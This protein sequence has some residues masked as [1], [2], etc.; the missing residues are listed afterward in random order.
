MR[1]LYISGALLILCVI[2]VLGQGFLWVKH[3][4][5]MGQNVPQFVV[6]DNQGNVYVAGNFNGE[7]LQNNITYISLGLQDMFLVKYD[8]NGNLLWSRQLGGS[9]TENVYGIALSTDQKSIYLGFTF[10]GTTNILG[11][12]LTAE[13]NDIAVAKITSNGDLEDLYLVA[14]GYNHQ[15]N[16]NL[17]VDNHNNLYVLGIFTNE[18]VIAGGA[19]YL[20]DNE[21]SN[22]QN[23][24]VKFDEW[25]NFKWVKLFETTSPLTYIRSITIYEDYIYLSGQFSGTLSFPNQ[26][27]VSNNSYRDGF[28]A[29]LNT[30]GE[31]IWVRRIRGSG[32]DIYIHRHNHDQQGNVYLAGYF[33]CSQLTI[34]S[35]ENNISNVFPQNVAAGKNDMLLL[36]YSSDGVLQ[37]VKNHGSTGDDRLY[38]INAVNQS[39]TASGCYGGNMTINGQNLLLKGGV[40]GCLL[41]GNANNGMVNKVVTA[42]GKNNENSW[43]GILTPTARSYY[44]MGEFTSDSLFLIFLSDTIKFRNP[45]VNYRDAYVAKMGCFEDINFV[46]TN[47]QCPG[48]SDGSITANPT[49]GNEPYSF[50]WSNQSTS[51]TITN[52]SAGL[53]TVTVTGTNNCTMIKSYQLTENPPLTATYTKSDPCPNSNNGTITALPNNGKPPYTYYWSN[54]KTT[55]TINNL[56]SGTYYCTIRDACPN[57]VVI[58]VTLDNPPTFSG[59]SI[60]STPSNRCVNTATFT[61]NPN[62]GKPPYSYVWKMDNNVVGTTQTIINRPPQKN[63]Y[64]TVTDA[65]GTTKSASRSASIL[66]ITLTPSSGCTQPGQC[67]GWAQVNPSNEYPP[68]S[69]LWAPNAGSQTTQR[70]INLCYNSLGYSV[71][72]TD[73][74]GCTYTYSGTG[75][76]VL[77]CSKSHINN[78][79]PEITVNIFPTPA[80][81]ILNVQFLSDRNYYSRL[82]IYSADGKLILQR[83]LIS[84]DMDIIIQTHTWSEGIYLLRL[85]SDEEVYS[86]PVIIKR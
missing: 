70:A 26:T 71:T 79:Y 27:I 50:L 84:T 35:T 64:V 85:E 16:G 44:F 58:T 31:D 62:G 37:W 47:V 67:T 66:N 29:Q 57:S 14:G 54:G 23:F 39:F 73:V 55:Q 86:R 11:A 9:G 18:A 36:K 19:D 2:H 13:Q 78:D 4:T 41:L 28:V 76:R 42:K 7:I 75:T 3:Y 30:N 46:A 61:A 49:S 43:T 32:N 48:G 34:D 5:G 52:L 38:Y 33:A 77:N 72:V 63:H 56:A 60:V 40:D 68:Y 21:Y 59:V 22:R 20:H 82:N 51:Q 81:D 65:C 45:R 10:N 17:A 12:E 8:A 15:V 83:N 53:Y 25:G 80:N 69:Y 24:L 74:Y 1:T 6:I